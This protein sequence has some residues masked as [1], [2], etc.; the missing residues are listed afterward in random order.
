MNQSELIADKIEEAIGRMF[1]AFS[2]YTPKV[3]EYTMYYDPDKHET[4]FIELYF[5]DKKSLRTAIED[6]M[7]F[8]VHDYLYTDL[9]TI[10]ELKNS[11][12]HIEFAAGNYPANNQEYLTRHDVLIEKAKRLTQ[13][14]PEK[15]QKRCHSCG[16]D[17]DSHQLRGFK[18]E[19]TGV[20]TKGWIV[21][22]EE[23][24][25]CFLT[26]SANPNSL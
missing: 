12:Y 9:G 10:D 15:A 11:T 13:T 17:F 7:C 4:W 5:S 16:H 1:Q 2:A 25:Y 20:M 19:E 22:P 18:D 6:G 14:Q 24:C 3:S 8:H 21:C 23:D 26:W